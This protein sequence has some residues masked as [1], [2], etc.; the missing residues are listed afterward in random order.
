[1]KHISLLA[2]G[3][4]VSRV[5][6]SIQHVPRSFF[7]HSSTVEECVT[8]R[9]LSVRELIFMMLSRFPINV[10]YFILLSFVFCSQ[11]FCQGG[12]SQFHHIGERFLLLEAV[13]NREENTRIVKTLAFK[14]WTSNAH[15]SLTMLLKKRHHDQEQD[16]V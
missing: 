4:G 7:L 9:T 8:Q 16:T 13:F 11:V 10:Y 15:N 1:M 3:Y 12:H 14:S 6:T 5:I 2:C